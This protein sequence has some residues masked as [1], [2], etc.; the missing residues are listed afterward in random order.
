MDTGEEEWKQVVG[1]RNWIDPTWDRGG[2]RTGSQEI[3]AR[4]S[5]RHED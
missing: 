1:H 2:R 4:P 3:H 5:V